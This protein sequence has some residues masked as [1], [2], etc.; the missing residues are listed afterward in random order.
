MNPND[1]MM[2]LRQ[3]LITEKGIAETTATQYLQ[4]L[5]KLNGS[6]NFTNLGFTRKP[7]EIEKIVETYAESTQRTQYAT[8]SAVLS[9]FKDKPAYKKTYQYW[10]DKKVEATKE[11]PSPNEKTEKQEENWTSWEE[12]Q[13]KKSD[14]LTALSPSSL[15]KRT[16]TPEQNDQLLQLLV[17]SLYTDIPPRRN[18]DYTSL[19]VVKKLPKEASTDKNYYDMT[20]HKFVF[21]KYK[22]AKT[23]GQQTIDAPP[24]LHNIIATYIKYHPNKKEKEIPLLPGLNPTNGI[25]RL[26][27]RIFNKKIG[28]SML[29]HIYLSDNLGEAIKEQEKL[30]TDMAHST[31][32]Q[33]DYIKH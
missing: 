19:V 18:Q 27:N 3:Q 12:V 33:R 31:S 4:T 5:Y 25:T 28:S 11:A 1:F 20:T 32:M 29:R 16:L 17:L 23:Y 30:A 7:E 10:L 24:E 26:L 21:N 13:K 15:T 14:L 9:L 2:N 22:T 8:L 6:K